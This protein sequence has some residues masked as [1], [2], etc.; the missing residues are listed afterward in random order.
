MLS[1]GS[2]V[3]S[4][5]QGLAA[6]MADRRTREPLPARYGLAL[7]LPPEKRETPSPGGGSVLTRRACAPRFSLQHRR[8]IAAINSTRL[9]SLRIQ[10]FACCSLRRN[11]FSARDPSP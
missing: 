1:E 7:R 4:I 6:N 11:R 10:I 2:T 8:T 9:R 5:G 3:V